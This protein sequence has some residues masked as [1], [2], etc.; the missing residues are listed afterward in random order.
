MFMK[1]Y[2]VVVIA[3]LTMLGA[4]QKKEKSDVLADSALTPFI[5]KW[6]KCVN[7][8]NGSHGSDFANGSSK[9]I[10]VLINANGTFSHT[11]MYFNGALNCQGGENTMSYFQNGTVTVKGAS[12]TAT[13]ATDIDFVSSSSSLTVRDGATLM[14]HDDFATCYPTANLQDT[15][16]GSVGIVIDGTAHRGGCATLVFDDLFGPTFQSYNSATFSTGFMT[17]AD[18]FDW[19][20]GVGTYPTTL[21]LTLQKI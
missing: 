2:A 19:D 5:G 1:S 16:P 21:N 12:A 6:G 10:E 15:T 11:R 18:P 4:C 8:T 20:M 17:I 13:G 7:F 3:A 14:V 9:L